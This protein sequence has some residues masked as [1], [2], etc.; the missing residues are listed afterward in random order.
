[1]KSS[2]MVA[3]FAG[4]LRIA[5]YAGAV[6]WALTFVGTLWFANDQASSFGGFIGPNE[7]DTPA[8]VIILWVI[9]DTWGYLLTAVVAFALSGLLEAML[10]DEVGG[11]DD[12]GSDGLGGPDGPGRPEPGPGRIVEH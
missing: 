2:S 1:M 7:E 8:A 9:R 6:I 10:A 5:G 12:D 11:G 3:T 4:W